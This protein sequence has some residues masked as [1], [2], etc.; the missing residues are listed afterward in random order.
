[1]F[2]QFLPR[3]GPLRSTRSRTRLMRS[4][5]QSPYFQR[6]GL[7]AAF[8]T[9]R[10]MEECRNGGDFVRIIMES[11]AA[12][13]GAD[14]WVECTPAHVCYMHR[15]K[16]TIPGAKFIHIIRDGRDVALSL[17]RLGWVRQF[18]WDRWHPLLPAGI[19]WDCMVRCGRR[20][21]K[22]LDSDYTEVHFETLITE[23]R[24]TLARLGTFIDHELNYDRI[25]QIAIGSV[26]DPNTAYARDMPDP[27]LRSWRHSSWPDAASPVTAP[28]RLGQNLR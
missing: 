15:I 14:R 10:V 21:G 1:M 25:Q 6:S 27:W 24:Q 17:N 28:R 5:I 12:A 11:I 13:Q 3:F 2:D 9:Q 22:M 8:L 20:A 7:D 23:P 16:A 19:S 4:W 26:R 18:S